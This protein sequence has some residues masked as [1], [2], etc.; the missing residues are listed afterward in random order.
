MLNDNTVTKLHELKMDVMAQAFKE[1]LLN[2]DFNSMAFEERLG[3]LVDA[4]WN[5]RKSN[6]LLRLI[7]NAGYEFSNAAVENI[8]YRADRKLD[9][10]QITALSTCNYI[11]EHHNI[12]IL[13]ATGN[14]KTYLSCAFGISANRNFYPVKY[15]RLPDLLA[16]LAIARSEHTYQKVVKKYKEVCLLILDDWLLFPLKENEA[17]DILDIVNSRHKRASTIFCSQFD[18]CDWHRKISETTVADAICDR[19]VNDSYSI[20]IDGESMRKHYGIKKTKH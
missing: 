8:N 17:R 19:I 10:T 12:I 18:T 6:R 9:K 20:F 5:T 1:Q 15:I 11:A 4:E 13:G 16:E 7:K 2:S 3:L 14:G